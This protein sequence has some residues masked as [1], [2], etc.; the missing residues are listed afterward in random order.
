[1]HH[2]FRAKSQ[3]EVPGARYKSVAHHCLD[4]AAT[5]WC[6]LDA[7]PR[8]LRREATLTG[9][10][11]ERHADLCALLAGLHDIGKFSI[12]FQSQVPDLWPAVALGR[13]PAEPLRTR[14]HWEG[15]ALILR[16]SKLMRVLAPVFG[17]EGM[18][19]PIIA[20]V[21]GHHGEA[22]EHSLCDAETWKADRDRGIGPVCV[23]AS[24]A[25]SA[26]LLALFPCLH[27]V[28]I[29]DQA[30]V[31][32]LL[33]GLITLADWVGS[34]TEHFPFEDPTVP[35][36]EYWPLAIRRAEQAL[37]SK[38]LMPAV[39][40]ALP[41]LAALSPHA[42]T[43]RP[44]QLLAAKLAIGTDPQIVVIEDGTGS[45]KTEAALLLAA[46][47]M[48]AGL[49]EG[50]FVALPTMATANA[51]HGRLEAAL[52]GL[53]QGDASLVLA[54]GKAQ[55]ASALDR[56]ET[57]TPGADDGEPA[58]RS[59][60]NAWIGDSRK[61][62]FL[63][64]AGAGT[65]DQAFLCVLPKKHLTLRQYALA[66]RIL[67]VDEA[68]TCDAY[69][70]E[71]LKTLLEL[72]ARFG[73]S[74]IILS[75]TLGRCM[76][77]DLA[78]AFAHGGG[79]IPSKAK[80]SFQA[81]LRS[82][83]YP[84][85]TR[86][87]ASTGVEEWPVE[88]TPELA[89]SVAIER[90]AS[91]VDAVALAFAKAGRGAAV[92]IICNA[93]DSAIETWQALLAAGHDPDRCHLF[94]ARFL[95]EDRLDIEDRVQAWFGR[96]SRP[97]DRRGRI[98][99]ATQ[100]V[101]QSLDVDF[102]VMISDLAPADLIVQRAGRLWRHARDDRPV[103]RPVLHIL[104]PDPA[105]VAD[106]RW[107]EPVLGP[108]AFVYDLQG[109]MWRSARDLLGKGR[110]ETPGDLRPLIE[111]AYDGADDDLPEVLKAEHVRSVGRSFGERSLGKHNTIDPSAGYA[112][113]TAPSADE[114][115]GTRL[116]AESVTLRLAAREG[117]TLVPL[118]RRP[119][120]NDRLD[121]A[122]SEVT[123]RKGWLE[124]AFGGVMPVP[125]D[126]AIVERVRAGW[127]EW[128]RAVPLYEVGE[129]DVLLIRGERTLSYGRT[130]GL[131][132]GNWGAQTATR[133][134]PSSLDGGR[135]KL[136]EMASP[137]TRG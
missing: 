68:H 51:M 33:N 9:L 71:E 117:D 69:M 73:G 115:I 105:A 137:H 118:R 21:A 129:D 86:W 35:T 29:D 11:I 131:R 66:G 25:Y 114:A 94:H 6:F 92:A 55:V 89:R 112:A 132:I 87:S 126:A 109:V 78:W 30:T 80:A 116:G 31:S 17:P 18:P 133:R 61:K 110:L 96:G 88:A 98:L 85:L 108:A 47:M 38:G 19:G 58:V 122:L 103:P 7:N 8:R 39:P 56:L 101:E 42:G 91:R 24:A 111:A 135:P 113:L 119:G 59:W 82:E 64:S 26:E 10:S 130:S 136:Y 83:Q 2:A 128:E 123:V 44:M 20:A 93:V 77:A 104:S 53:F 3:G 97:D 22:P 12:G 27:D 74:A 99:V 40:C 45:G 100:V 125:A 63:A 15:T 127:P 84:L 48:A 41:S 34:D 120:A 57:D 106:P 14:S 32:F 134:T 1:M 79:G 60:F 37:R 95:V 5:A 102:D 121:W 4:V 52:G 36:S 90:I 75:A 70:G 28:I 76:R 72:H 65:I 50:V 16:S 62:A 46:R 13:R 43:P 107:L 124:R 49:G 54:H 67:I 23:E 81:D